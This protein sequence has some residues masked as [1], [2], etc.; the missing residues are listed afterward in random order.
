M[1]TNECTEAPLRLDAATNPSLW[2]PFHT[3]ALALA[4]ALAVDGDIGPLFGLGL[5]LAPSDR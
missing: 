3:L 2:C 1:W 4:L 5:G